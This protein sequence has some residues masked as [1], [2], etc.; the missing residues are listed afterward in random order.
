MEGREWREQG[1]E[2]VSE[3]ASERGREGGR[4]TKDCSCVKKD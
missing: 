3:L 2:R 1:R 4:E